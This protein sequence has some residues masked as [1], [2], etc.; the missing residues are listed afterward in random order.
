MIAFPDIEGAA[1]GLDAFNDRRH[2]HIR[3]GVTVAVRVSAEVI[4]DQVAADLEELSDGFTMIPC[5]TRREILGSFD[6][7]RCGLDWKTRYGNRRTRTAGI[8]VKD[9]LA[10]VDA[11]GRVGVL[12][13]NLGHVGRDRHGLSA[14]RHTGEL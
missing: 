12:N 3:I 5:D 13:V 14:R 9:I 7:T 1:V 11:L 6:P 8:R 2:H 4:G 10:H